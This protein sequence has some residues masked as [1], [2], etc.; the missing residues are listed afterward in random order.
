MT[1][2][3]TKARVERLEEAARLSPLEYEVAVWV[4]RGARGAEIA[5]RLG[6]PVATI[7]ALISSAMY[8]SGC[9]DVAELEAKLKI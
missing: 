9:R 2:R 3:K 5:E 4:G 7:H 8:Y 6:F 1:V